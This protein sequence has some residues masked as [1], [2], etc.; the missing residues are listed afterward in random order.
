MTGCIHL[1]QPQAD[2]LPFMRTHLSM[3]HDFIAL[4]TAQNTK[5]T[6]A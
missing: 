4:E 1:A 3:T 6:G 2:P 5:K